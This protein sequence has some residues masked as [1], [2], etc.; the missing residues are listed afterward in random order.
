MN[1][2]LFIFYPIKRIKKIGAG[3]PNISSLF[4]PKF[5]FQLIFFSLFSLCSRSLCVFCGS[6]KRRGLR[7]A[8]E[9]AGVVVVTAWWLIG[10]GG[11]GVVVDLSSKR[12]G[13]RFARNGV[14]LSSHHLKPPATTRR[15]PRLQ[16]K[17]ILFL[18]ATTWNH[19]PP[20]GETHGSFLR[21]GPTEASHHQGK[22][23]GVALFSDL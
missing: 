5:S 17:K 3:P 19:Q 2:W 4:F 21:S 13:L 8:V 7:F 14:D 23:H 6:L 1:S 18:A 20:P 22:T 9:N 16:K 10:L 15:D 11:Y 12:R